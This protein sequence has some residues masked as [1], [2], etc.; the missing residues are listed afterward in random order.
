MTGAGLGLGKNYL[1]E[2]RTLSGSGKS[3]EFYF[4]T[5]SD[6]KTHRILKQLTATSKFQNRFFI[7]HQIQTQPGLMD[8]GIP[9]EFHF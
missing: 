2:L 1:V 4:G 3:D 9:V 5:T 7:I 8:L 6:P